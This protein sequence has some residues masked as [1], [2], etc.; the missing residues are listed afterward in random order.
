[1]NIDMVRASDGIE[2]RYNWESVWK[3]WLVNARGILY[4]SVDKQFTYTEGVYLLG[5]LL[6]RRCWSGY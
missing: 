4:Y 5:A 2:A 3:E 1:M 6:R